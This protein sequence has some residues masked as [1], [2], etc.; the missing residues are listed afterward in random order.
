M[1]TYEPVIGLEVHVQ[2]ATATKLFCPCRVAYGA[3]PNSLVCAVC[4]GYPGALPTLNQQA[5]T[6]GIRAALAFGCEIHS[7]TKFDRKNYFYP[8]L[9]K[10]YQISQ[11]DR[12]YATGGAVPVELDDGSER[13]IR[14]QRIHLEEDAGKSIHEGAGSNSR[15][16]LNRCGT[17]LLEMVSEPVIRSPREA[18][19]YVRTIRDTMRW[20]GVSDANMEEGSLRCDVNVSLRPQGA[21]EFGT[22]AEVK[23]L[24]SFAHVEKALELEIERQ[25]GLLSRGQP[26]VQETRLFDADRVETRTMRSKE[27]AEDY[28]YFPEP[29]LPMLTIEADRVEQERLALP[30]SARSRRQRYE[31]ELELSRYDAGILVQSRNGA[32]YFDEVV[33]AGAD[34]KAAANWFQTEILRELNERQIAVERLPLR[35]AG[36]AEI[37]GAVGAERISVAM[38]REVLREAVATGEDPSV[39]LERR[40]EQVSDVSALEQWVVA[41]LEQNADAVAKIRAGDGKPK[42]FLVGQ[43]MKESR[44]QA[45]PRK[46][47][48]MIDRK[49]S[50][51]S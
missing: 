18:Y 51:S 19:H 29:D 41:V 21:E 6:L 30:E 44:G 40:G 37:L 3:P 48:E 14:L 26:V 1:T 38:G 25:T 34:P 31:S 4:L 28:R 24:N 7:P 39:L 35:P 36:L 12:P 23:N 15:I 47:A 17:P 27:E 10:G 43:V 42:G 33:A 16:D 8:D 13:E 5:V 46:V 20:L 45:N 50:E 9:P 32:D 49:V 11:F 22:R 2:L